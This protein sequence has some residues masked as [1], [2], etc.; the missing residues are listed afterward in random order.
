M[1]IRTKALITGCSCGVCKGTIQAYGCVIFKETG[2][3][4]KLLQSFQ[5]N[6]SCSDCGLMYNAN[7]IRFAAYYNEIK[8]TLTEDMVQ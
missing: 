3:G 7:H 2:V 4:N 1:S 5:I 8:E 6:T